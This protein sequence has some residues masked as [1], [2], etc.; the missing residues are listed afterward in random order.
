[1]TNATPID[2]RTSDSGCAGDLSN[3]SLRQRHLD[4]AT[5]AREVADDANAAIA[6]RGRFGVVLAGGRTVPTSSHRSAPTNSHTPGSRATR[7]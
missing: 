7:S 5:F 1:M 2:P 3:G 4:V 6:E